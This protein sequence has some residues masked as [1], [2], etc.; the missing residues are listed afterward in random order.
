MK[1]K[2]QKKEHKFVNPFTRGVTYEQFIDSMP[3]DVKLE[4][5]LKGKCEPEQIAWLKDE[6]TNFK[7]K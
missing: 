4:E 6:L 7:N 1:F 3:K 5:Y 2:K